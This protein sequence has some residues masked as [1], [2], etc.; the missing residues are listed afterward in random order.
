MTEEKLEASNGPDD[1]GEPDWSSVEVRIQGP[2]QQLAVRFDRDVIAWFKGQGT[3]YQ[4]RRHAVP[5]SFVDA[6]KER[7][8]TVTT[9]DPTPLTHSL[10][11]NTLPSPHR[12]RM[13][14]VRGDSVPHAGNLAACRVSDDA[15][16]GV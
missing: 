4:M 3:G 6:Q 13:A 5:S 11:R 9:N 16:G 15:A 12:M 7:V 1:E 10:G 2:K 8:T 14:V